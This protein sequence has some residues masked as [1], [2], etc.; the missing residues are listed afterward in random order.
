MTPTERI[1]VIETL[2][3]ME[4]HKDFA[5]K[6]GLV[7]KTKVTISERRT[8]MVT[9]EIKNQTE[10][11]EER[12][13]DLNIVQITICKGAGCRACGNPTYPDCMDSCP[14]FDD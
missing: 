11:H 4:K 8:D 9:K 7:N 6:I 2:E 13:K 10:N 3:L 5:K 1:S 12:K 14:L